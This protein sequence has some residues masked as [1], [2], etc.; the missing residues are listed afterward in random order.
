M[1]V[2]RYKLG[3]A[4]MVLSIM[5]RIIFGLCYRLFISPHLACFDEFNH[6]FSYFKMSYTV[7]VTKSA[8]QSPASVASG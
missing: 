2:T 4:C 3:E 6:L 8:A 5:D 1:V 7:L